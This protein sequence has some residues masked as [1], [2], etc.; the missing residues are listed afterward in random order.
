MKKLLLWP[1]LLGL[2]F[3]QQAYSQS[4]TLEAVQKRGYLQCGVSMGLAGFSSPDSQGKWKGID[5]E[6]CEAIA[7]AIFNDR[8]K[9]R[10]V[11]LSAQQRF[12]AVQSGEIDVLS[13]NTT[14]SLSRETAMGLNFGPVVLY[15]GQGFLVK[16]KANV[17]GVKDLAGAS[18]C[19]QQGTSTELNVADYFRTNNIKFK[20]V[21]FESNEQVVQAFLQGR[22][23]AY[24]A[25]ASG[26]A[27]ERSK[28]KNPDEYEILTEV[29]SKEP[30]SPAVR[31]GDDAW[32]D[33]V[34]FV[35]YALIEAEELG[36]TSQNVDEKLEA[37]DPRIRRLL[38]VVEGNGKA[39]GLSEKWAYQIIKVLGNYGEI[40]E[41]NIGQGSPLKLERGLNKLWNDGGLM[42]APPLR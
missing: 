9:V 10:Y 17:K 37:L 27:A 7:L 38:G 19:T 29:I 8:N 34:S 23:D 14:R 6:I 30:L 5:A 22:C 32:Y 41:R 33:I 35:I 36:V 31:H 25:D 13:R 1:F 16:K 20:P 4:T 2:T 11:S 42:Y 3:T 28:L 15:D 21:V 24:T 26:L 18:I 40:F 39:L 12:T